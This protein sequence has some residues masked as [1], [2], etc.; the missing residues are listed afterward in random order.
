MSLTNVI[1]KSKLLRWERPLISFVIVCILA[2]AVFDIFEDYSDNQSNWA[3]AGDLV[4][5]GTIILVLV[6][7]WHLTP[8]SLAKRNKLLTRE[9]S[10]TNYEASQ[11]QQRA[12]KLM[13]GLGE[14]VQQQFNSWNLS[15]AEQQVAFL[16]LKGLSHNEIALIRQTKSR[17][18]RQQAAS[19]Y[20]KANLNNRA[21]LSAFFLEDLWLVESN[22]LKV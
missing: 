7:L 11:W 10:K 1:S 12:A 6:Y 18:V 16:L 5:M 19:I 3:I 20:K 17:T 22:E 4:Y 8:F 13:R 14:M 21:E 15:V 9:I 2:L